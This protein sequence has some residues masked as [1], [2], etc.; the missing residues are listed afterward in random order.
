MIIMTY[1]NY[2]DLQRFVPPGPFQ[3]HIGCLLQERGRTSMGAV[4][5]RLSGRLTSQ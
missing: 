2:N 3:P 4:L 1:E 5:A